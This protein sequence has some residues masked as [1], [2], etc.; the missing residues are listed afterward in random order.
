MLG[1]LASGALQFDQT[2]AQFHAPVGLATD[3]TPGLAAPLRRRP[4]GVRAPPSA[5]IEGDW[6][7]ID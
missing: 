7:S 3:N 5:K 4:H 1:T 6:W 2:G